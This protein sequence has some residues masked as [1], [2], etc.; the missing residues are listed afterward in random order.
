MDSI[1]T[2]FKRENL[3]LFEESENGSKTFK[4]WQNFKI[5]LEYNCQE[6]SKED[7]KRNGKQKRQGGSFRFY[8]DR[9]IEIGTKR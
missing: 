4:T 2:D 7:T 3:D 1:G 8:K 6:D 5:A 9:F